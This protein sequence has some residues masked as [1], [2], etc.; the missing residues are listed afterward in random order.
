LTYNI[1]GAFNNSYVD[2]FNNSTNTV[3]SSYTKIEIG[4]KVGQWYGYQSYKRLF[5]SAEE[6][7]ALRT[8]TE[9]GGINSYWTSVES[10][11][12]VYLVDQNGDGKI[13][14][15]DKVYLGTQVPKL[16]GGMG[17]QL[18]IGNSLN[19]GAT[20]T[21][22]LGNKR[23]WAMPAS[24]VGYTGNYNQS[25]KIAGMS[26]TMPKNSPYNAA[27]MPNATPY[28]DGS[29]GT[30]SDYWLYD[31]S[32]LRLNAINVSYRMDKQYFR[33]SIVDNIE[34]TLQASNL[35][36]LTRYPGFDPQGN[37]STSTSLTSTMGVD[38][39]TYPS[40]KTFTAGVKLTFR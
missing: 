22:S 16:Y 25:N 26:A 32:Y 15:D 23:Y 10:D 5:G 1:N 39:S 6:V 12:D 35:F 19:I 2:R 7:T 37:F 21:Y 33:N 27:T 9:T 30:F 11:G 31:G 17:L 28:G 20:F 8:R 29:N 13:N 18:Y 36:T 38:N 4:Q 40:A 34:F 14:T 24:D 3:T